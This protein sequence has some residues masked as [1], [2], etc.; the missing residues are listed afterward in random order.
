MARQW[1]LWPALLM[2]VLRALHP[3]SAEA[4]QWGSA[5]GDL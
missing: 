5:Y 3:V 1:L 4:A 2:V